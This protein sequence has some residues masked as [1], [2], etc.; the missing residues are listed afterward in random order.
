MHYFEVA[1]KQIIRA[2]Q[3]VFT[4]QSAEELKIGQ[5]VTI[6]VGKKSTIGVV[7]KQ[8]TKPAFET[9]PI[10][11]IIEAKP[12]PQA[13]VKLAFWMA[14]Y[15][16]TPLPKVLQTLLPSGLTKNR[17]AKETSP[18]KSSLKTRTNFVLNKDQT[19]VIKQ[20]SSR[21]GETTILHGITGS[22]KTAVYIELARQQ[23][24]AGKSVI[25]I[26][27]EIALTSQIVAQFSLEFDSVILTHS[28]QTEAEKH[29]AWKQA[30]STEQ[31]QIIIGPRSALFMPVQSIGLIV[32]DECHEPSLKQEQAP[33]YSALRASTMLGKY[34]G[35]ITLL[36]SATP[37]VA[38]YYIAA[39]KPGSIVSLPNLARSDARQPDIELIDM[40]NRANFK[41]HRF[42]SDK[43]LGSIDKSIENG[44][45]SLIFHNRRG[46]TTTSLC[47]NCGWMAGC[48]NCFV[49]LT[50][51]TDSHNMRCHI[52]GLN[53]RIPT[54]CP[55]C[56]NT[57]IIHKGIGTKL[58]EAEIQ[59]LYPKQTVVRFD[60][61][62][63]KDESL[64]SRYDQL[65]SGEIDIIIGTQ[66][67]AKGLDLPN[68]KTVGIIQADAGLSLPDYTSSERVFQLL[69]QAIGRVG[70]SNSQTDAIIQSYQPNHPAVQF[71]IKQDYE[72]FYR[73]T[74]K[75][76]AKTNFPPYCYLLKLSCSYKT[77][78]TAIKNS[79][80][81][82]RDIAGKYKTVQVL[83]PSPAF[84][85]RAGGNYRWQ[86][87]VKSSR[88]QTL[89]DIAH[90]IPP[91]GWSYELDPVS[92]L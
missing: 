12:L 54:S 42:L 58:I 89:I 80:Q 59:K 11:D 64:S 70:R 91:K 45:Q 5:L 10:T 37:S 55:E 88:R 15:Y 75:Q 74:V 6:P 9:K 66:I 48:P 2:D 14:Q 39:S 52:C 73:L 69:A 51:H 3:T 50:L 13:L 25:I 56:H 1:P 85:E 34:S 31:P 23:I 30:L 83:G 49:P 61:D 22:G 67:V 71:G 38:D 27:P 28:R 79:K 36:G 90:Q 20:L 81:L 65:H 87:V 7:T 40:T 26:V 4:Y 43:L 32:V 24:K 78:A 68:L 92:L 44:Q 77:E 46:S 35:S 29:L 62:N 72:S 84:Y 19:E 60:A 16:E 41:R 57:N 21:Q 76:R 47:D 8:V 86:V 82:A 63:S 17:R 18:S 33:R 53:A